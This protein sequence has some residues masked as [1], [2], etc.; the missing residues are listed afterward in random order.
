MGQNG[1]LV[2]NSCAMAKAKAVFPVPGGPARRT[3]LPAIF[4]DFMRSTT[5]PAACLE[6]KID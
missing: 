1:T 4:L 2:P 5:T 3:A 6:R